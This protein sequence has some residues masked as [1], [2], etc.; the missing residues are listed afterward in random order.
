MTCCGWQSWDCPAGRGSTGR[1]HPSIRGGSED[2]AKGRAVGI[3]GVDAE[4]RIPGTGHP[5]TSPTGVPPPSRL[6]HMQRSRS[7]LPARCQAAISW[8]QLP[9]CAGRDPAGP[10]PAPVSSVPRSPASH[11]S[12]SPGWRPALPPSPCRTGELPAM[13]GRAGEGGE[14][15]RADPLGAGLLLEQSRSP[16]P[17]RC[18]GWDSAGKG[19]AGHRAVLP[20]GCGPALAVLL[21]FRIR[22]WR[23]EAGPACPVVG[24]SAGGCSA[25]G[26]C[27]RVLRKDLTLP[28]IGVAPGQCGAEPGKALSLH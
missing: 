13:P 4:E 8:E 6:G 25:P 24:L 7:S 22:M 21:T 11:A 19:W 5:V 20:A 27:P 17:T 9:V 28:E 18:G 12:R 14:P 15:S 3:H 10:R 23:E 1:A 26:H 2:T 16:R